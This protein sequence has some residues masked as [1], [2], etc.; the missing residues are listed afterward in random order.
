MFVAA[1][2]T[3]LQGAGHQR[4]PSEL[5]ERQAAAREPQFSRPWALT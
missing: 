5:V 1:F 2:D 3:E 4:I